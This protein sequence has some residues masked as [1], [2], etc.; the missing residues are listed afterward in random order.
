MKK[1]LLILLLILSTCF[2][3]YFGFKNQSFKDK[4]EVIEES[5]SEIDLSEE[6]MLAYKNTLKKPY[7]QKIRQTIDNYNEGK[8]SPEDII[9]EPSILSEDTSCGMNSFDKSYFEGKFFVSNVEDSLTGGINVDIIFLEKPEKVFWIWAYNIG[10]DE[11]PEYEIRSFC[12]KA[13]FTKE[14]IDDIWIKPYKKYILDP[15]YSV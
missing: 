3:L 10:D 13:D 15:E 5:V 7:V 1:L 14:D 4:Q 11:N 12:D 6:D 9:V 8:L 2:I